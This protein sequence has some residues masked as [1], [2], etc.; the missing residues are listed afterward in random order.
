MGSIKTI[1]L[2]VFLLVL[3]FLAGCASTTGNDVNNTDTTTSENKVEIRGFA[4][5]PG[6]LTVNVGTTVT[7]TNLDSATHT[8]ASDDGD[9]ESNDL[10]VNG[11][12]SK[13]FDSP[14]TYTYHCSI[15]PEMTGTIEVT[16]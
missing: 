4:F 9:W 11:T 6:T 5:E 10:A 14:G 8:I 2:S 1:L 13:T 7:W 12:Y 16:Q 3:V 15:H